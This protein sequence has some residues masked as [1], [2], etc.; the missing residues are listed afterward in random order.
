M[1]LGVKNLLANAREVGSI[2][3]WVRSPREG[4]G[5]P[6]QYSW[7]IPWT[8]E[9]GGLQSLVVQRVGHDWT[10]NTFTLH[11]YRSIC[12]SI[13]LSEPLCCIPETN[14]TLSINYIWIRK[15]KKK[16]HP[17][18]F[19][20]NRWKAHRGIRCKHLASLKKAAV[21][22]LISTRAQTAG[23]HLVS[24]RML[25]A[26]FLGGHQIQTSEVYLGK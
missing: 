25:L 26:M 19:L 23:W 16:I 7:R 18:N 21:P 12:L 6:L 8:E 9:P 3:G 10:P 24:L 13:Y 1:A 15:L 14:T 5:N 4:L 20:E 22:L 11:I 2:P 17:A